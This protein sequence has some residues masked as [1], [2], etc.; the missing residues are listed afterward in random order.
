[1]PNYP[2]VGEPPLDRP[3]QT[4]YFNGLTEFGAA[5]SDSFWYGDQGPHWRH[6][7]ADLF[8][9][10]DRTT[11]ALLRIEQGIASDTEVR[12]A[13]DYCPRRSTNDF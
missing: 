11:I 1:M 6:A 2:T 12:D 3:I 10:L 13:L 7:L 8:D 5:Y 4:R 9:R